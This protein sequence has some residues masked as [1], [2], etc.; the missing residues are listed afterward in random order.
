MKFRCNRQ[1]LADAF[2]TAA[3][4]IPSR[5]TLPILSN[6][7]VQAQGKELHVI[8][9]DGEMGIRFTVTTAEVL[10]PGAVVLPAGKVSAILREGQD[11]TLTV[12][13]DG[14]LTNLVGVSS[15]FKVVGAD[16]ADYPGVPEFDSKGAIEVPGADLH[17][18]VKMVAFAVAHEVTRYALNG[19][20]FNL[21]GTDFRL[22]ASDGKRL[23]QVR[24]KNAKAPKAEVRVIIPVKALTLLER[25]IGKEDADVA[26]NLHENQVRF[27]TSH[28]LVFSRLVEGAFPDYEAVIPE[29]CDKKLTLKTADLL[30]ALRQADVLASEK[31]KATK[32]TLRDNKL[33]FLTRSAEHGES[34]VEMTV[35]YGGAPFECVFNPEYFIACL[36]VIEEEQISL[37][38]K[39]K[40]SP[41]VIRLGREYLSL[42]MPLTVEV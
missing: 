28:A 16:P 19:I 33:S 6:V 10:E 9:Q 35:E 36:Q 7:L 30:S 27:R 21:K 22:V 4:A 25:V 17:R 11:E 1:N 26:M 3:L 31:A 34:R 5:T 37:E 23:A 12:E 39:D 41:G 42:I 20:L 24:R 29:D 40:A 38:L 13:T 15:Q 2:A 14:N 32:F 18:M 8:A